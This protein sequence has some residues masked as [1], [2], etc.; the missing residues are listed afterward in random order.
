[1][2]LAESKYIP[3]TTRPL[4]VPESISLPSFSVETAKFTDGSTGFV[5][6]A[7]DL[8]KN[9]TIKSI[10]TKFCY[11]PCENVIVF[12]G[13]DESIITVAKDRLSSHV[14]CSVVLSTKETVVRRCV[15]KYESVD[16]TD[17][18]ANLYSK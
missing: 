12:V 2:G 17:K 1:M 9:S 3:E 14:V 7:V 4:I 18:I 15:E 10:S 16:E 5:V 13:N 8:A 11:S 6:T